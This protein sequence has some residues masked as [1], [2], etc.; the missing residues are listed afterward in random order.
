MVNYSLVGF[1]TLIMYDN[2]YGRYLQ[3][4]NI[5]CMSLFL[6]LYTKQTNR[7]IFKEILISQ[8]P[9]KYYGI[10][11]VKKKSKKILKGMD[12]TKPSRFPEGN[13]TNN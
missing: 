4:G 12:K 6:L 1:R 10:K 7:K 9:Y 11:T 2:I 13:D 3:M 5:S 8:I